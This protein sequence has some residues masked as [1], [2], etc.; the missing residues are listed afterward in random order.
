[1][2]TPETQTPTQAPTNGTPATTPEQ[3]LQSAMAKV[4]SAISGSPSQVEPDA[5]PEAAAPDATPPEEL[6]SQKLA[7]L[8]RKEKFLRDKEK[9]SKAAL[10]AREAELKGREEKLT[11]VEKM[12]AAFDADPLEFLKSRGI[13]EKNWPDIA[14]R[15]WY[16]TLGDQ[17]PKDFQAEIKTTQK[18]KEL[19]KALLEAR[20]A[21]EEMGKKWE[22]YQKQDETRRQKETE[23]QQIGAYQQTVAKSLS[24]LPEDLPLLRRLV[25]KRPDEA[26]ESMMSL[27]MQWAT[28]NE[29]ATELPSHLDMARWLEEGLKASTDWIREE[30]EA[31]VPGKT[32]RPAKTL[33]AAKAASPTTTRPPA[34][35]ADERLRRGLE[36]F[37]KARTGA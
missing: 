29:E 1:M 33:S 23:A 30:S 16:A 25:A 13:P 32:T 27:A 14:K 28:E 7:I 31:A 19:E 20:Q 35:T 6:P 8:A 12:A 11:A 18:T 22:E 36:A 2:T 3:R 34:Q 24:E 4:Q 9:Q 17:A 5:L 10:E 15:I 26:V 37:L 21:Q